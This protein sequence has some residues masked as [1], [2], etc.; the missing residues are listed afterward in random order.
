ME[1]AAFAS[2]P[3][4]GVG[5]ATSQRYRVTRGIN[6]SDLPPPKT[7][8]EL[9]SLVLDTQE[10]PSGTAVF[11]RDRQESPT[12]CS[13]KSLFERMLTEVRSWR[14]RTVSIHATDSWLRYNR[15]IRRGYRPARL[16]KR[17]ALGSVVLYF[18]NETVNILTHLLPCFLLICLLLW[19]PVPPTARYASRGPVEPQEKS[20]SAYYSTGAGMP[21]PPATSFA[22]GQAGT[23]TTVPLWLR[24]IMSVHH[25]LADGAVPPPHHPNRYIPDGVP[26]PRDLRHSLTPRAASASSLSGGAAT[27]VVTTPPS[28]SALTTAERL[29]AALTP[30]LWCLLATFALSAVYHTFMPCCQSIRSYQQLLQCDVLGVLCSITGSAHAFFLC[31]LPCDADATSWSS[32]RTVAAAL[33][34]LSSCFCSYALFGGVL[35]ETVPGLV[36]WGCQLA[37]EAVGF[38]VVAVVEYLQGGPILVPPPQSDDMVRIW[39]LRRR[40]EMRRRMAA[41][42]ASSSPSPPLPPPTS[43]AD[44]SSSVLSGGQRNGHTVEV[45]GNDKARN[46]TAAAAAETPCSPSPV[47]AMQ[48]AMILGC[49]C[50]LHFLSFLLL[51]YPKQLPSYGGY[52]QAVQYHLH[53]YFWLVVG[54]VI[55]VLRFPEALL[56]SATR[57]AAQLEQ[58]IQ[59]ANAAAAVEEKLSR[60]AAMPG[61]RRGP[62]DVSPKRLAPSPSL[63]NRFSFSRFLVTYVISASSLDYIGNSHNIWHACTVLSAFYQLLAVYYDCMEYDLVRCP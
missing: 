38:A 1:T 57:R 59:L 41:W 34:L 48:R 63:S 17:E 60:E 62:R 53:S 7:S 13:A 29:D 61:G 55:N 10:N 44:S 5:G 43:L 19:P 31:G 39:L 40:H 21:P 24:G 46:R 3:A 45:E 52:T 28:A 51:V 30:L 8:N 58:Q 42:A 14:T 4:V 54:G 25:S 20:S 26:S 22:A 2:T 36:Q 47:S 6:S 49:H 32:L 11:R 33:L 23:E 12:R 50:L 16:R 9:P 27:P 15:Y 56:F 18:H 35:R 37:Q